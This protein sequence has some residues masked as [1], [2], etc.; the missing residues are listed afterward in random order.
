METLDLTQLHCIPGAVLLRGEVFD[1]LRKL[2]EEGKI[3]A[4]GVSVESVE[5]A[6]ICLGQD[7]L[8]SLQVIFNIFRQKPAASLLPAA[9]AR[10]VGIIVRL[11][12]ASGLLGG[13]MS[14]DT[15]FEESDHR[16]YNRDGAGFNVGETFAGLGFETGVELA[17]A[18]KPLIPAG[19]SMAEVAQRWIL[20]HPAVSTVITGASKESQVR[21]NAPV[22]RFKPLPAEL[23][24]TLASFYREEVAAKIRGPY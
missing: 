6:E 24:E 12:L 23:H 21:D 8:T 16:H 9:Q 22:S 4:F 17:D 10:G 11:P 2:K 14:K 13:R 20:D 19:M 18:L 5:E 15:K 1:W 3:R 7:G